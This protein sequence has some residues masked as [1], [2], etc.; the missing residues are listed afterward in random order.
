MLGNPTGPIVSYSKFFFLGIL[1][2]F[3][4]AFYKAKYT[5]LFLTQNPF[6]Y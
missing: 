2:M 4:G 3:L 5:K 1:F 6:M